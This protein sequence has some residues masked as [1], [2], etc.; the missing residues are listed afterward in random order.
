MCNGVPYAQVKDFFR[1]YSMNRHKAT[2]LT[3]SYHMESY[4]PDD[5]RYDHRQ[6]LYN[7]RC[8]R[9]LGWGSRGGGGCGVLMGGAG[10]FDRTAWSHCSFGCSVW[11]WQCFHRI[12]QGRFRV[13][14]EHQRAIWQALHTCC[15]A[16]SKD[17]TPMGGRGSAG[18]SVLHCAPLAQ[19]PT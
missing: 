19:C 12:G 4:S 5:N 7:V 1:Y 10:A 8:V 15:S 9:Q 14:L 13:G 17:A 2:V 18:L 6:F 3:P 11:P 16:V